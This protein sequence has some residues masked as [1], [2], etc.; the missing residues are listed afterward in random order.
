ML[1]FLYV[2]HSKRSCG[3][4]TD[5]AETASVERP[6]PAGHLQNTVGLGNERCGEQQTFHL[7]C[8]I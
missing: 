1:R 3:S 5:Q 4:S 6:F 2:V 7:V 8:F